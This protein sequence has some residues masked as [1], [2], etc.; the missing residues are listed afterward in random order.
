[1]IGKK[2]IAFIH[3]NNWR[4]TKAN[5]PLQIDYMYIAKGFNGTLLELQQSFA[6]QKLILDGSLSKYQRN[7]LQKMSDS[8]NIPIHNIE[9]EG[10]LRIPIA[11]N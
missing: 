3:N 1:M 4:K 6:I 2:N 11:Q 8:L 10:A 7:R 5:T 9:T